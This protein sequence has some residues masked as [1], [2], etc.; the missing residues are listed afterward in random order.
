[1]SRMKN[2]QRILNQI[3]TFRHA[4]MSQSLRVTLHRSAGV[5]TF[6]IPLS[7]SHL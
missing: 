2:L 1:M 5:F 7:L 6:V 3:H 4:Q